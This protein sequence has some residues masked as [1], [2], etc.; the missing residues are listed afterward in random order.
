MVLNAIERHEVSGLVLQLNRLLYKYLHENYYYFNDDFDH[1][2]VLKMGKK[3]ILLLEMLQDEYICI[4]E[5]WGRYLELLFVYDE[6]SIS[7]IISRNARLHQNH[8]K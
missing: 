1:K 3:Q 7:W 4:K 8:S 5:V 6:I 2:H